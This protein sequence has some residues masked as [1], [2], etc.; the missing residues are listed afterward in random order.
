MRT[1]VRSQKNWK[2]KENLAIT[3]RPLS[4]PSSKYIGNDLVQPYCG[5][6]DPENK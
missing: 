2:T 6:A 5:G 3:P 4:Y 1:N